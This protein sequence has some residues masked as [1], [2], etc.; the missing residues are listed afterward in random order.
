MIQLCV[1]DPSPTSEPLA[2][3]VRYLLP[4]ACG[5]TIA[6]GPSQA[7]GSVTCECGQGVEVPRL[8]DLREL[9]V[10]ADTANTGKGWSFR[11]GVLSAG[12]V[13]AAL[14]AGAAGWFEINE[15]DPPAP[16]NAEARAEVVDRNLDQMAPADL[17]KLLSSVY[18]PAVSQGFT[19]AESPRE[20]FIRRAIELSQQYQRILLLTAAGVLA[21][22]V[23]LFAVSPK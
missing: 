23:V 16:F 11:M 5:K 15:P 13:L 1:P 10:E 20:E 2:V 8:R 4:C 14:L 19:V 7:G 18:E 17:V 21:V 3:S 9:P 12:L 22:T 6:V